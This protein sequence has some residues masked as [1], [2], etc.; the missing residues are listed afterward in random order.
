[1]SDI[2]DFEVSRRNLLLGT[3]TSAAIGTIASGAYAE[4]SEP[5]AKAAAGRRLVRACDGPSL[6]ESERRSAGPHR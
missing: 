4:I 6:T 2:S 3:S 1:M 5:S